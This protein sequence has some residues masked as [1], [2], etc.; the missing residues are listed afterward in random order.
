MGNK[1]SETN[2]KAVS[3]CDGVYIVVIHCEVNQS[4]AGPHKNF[5]HDTM[6]FQDFNRG[7]IFCILL[8]KERF[9]WDNG[10][11]VQEDLE[12]TLIYFTD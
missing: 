11:S 2:R 8:V 10:G 5:R 3:R 1:G 9:N 4:F 7:L 12:G 6:R